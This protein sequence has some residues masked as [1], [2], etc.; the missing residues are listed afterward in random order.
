VDYLC[1]VIVHF[2]CMN[3]MGAAPMGRRKGGSRPDVPE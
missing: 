3:E 1:H 2:S